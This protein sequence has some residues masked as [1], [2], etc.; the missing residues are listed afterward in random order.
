MTTRS[1]LQEKKLDELRTI[2]GSLEIADHDSLQKSKLIAAILES[3]GFDASA[4]PAPVDLPEIESRRDSSASAATETKA[5]SK[6]ASKPASK[7]GSSRPAN[8]EG[9]R[10]GNRDGNRQGGQGGQ[11]GQ[12]RR[13]SRGGQ[14]GGGQRQEQQEWD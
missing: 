2:A 5:K 14:V 7:S 4:E 3:D 8:R 1:K 9:D 6:E 13:R 12:R 10:D 11:G